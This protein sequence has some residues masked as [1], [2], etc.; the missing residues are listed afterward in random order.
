[1][2][3]SRKSSTEIRQLTARFR[4]HSSRDPEDQHGWPSSFRRSRQERGA[5]DFDLPEPDADL[6]RIGR[7]SGNREIR[8]SFFPSHHR[9]IHDS[10][11]R[12]RG[13][14][15]G[16]SGHS[17]DL[18]RPRRSGSGERSQTSRNSWRDSACDFIRSGQHRPS[19]RNSFHRLRA[20]RRSACCRT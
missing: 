3:T 10:R 17:V 18:S 8:A 11:K 12:S 2:K 9:G 13:E 16:G 6:R 19:F 4:A 20:G 14:A 15:H 5:I 1:M 7:R